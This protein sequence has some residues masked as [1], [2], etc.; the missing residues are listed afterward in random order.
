M[1]HNPIFL[2]GKWHI[3]VITKNLVDWSLMDFTG[4]VARSIENKL[5]FETTL[6]V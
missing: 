6:R 5:V 3:G 1:N 4:I 2:G